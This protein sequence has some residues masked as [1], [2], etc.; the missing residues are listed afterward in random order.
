M[1]IRIF[2]GYKHEDRK[3]AG[4][5]K[6]NLE[7]FGFSVFLAHED[8]EASKDWIEVILQELRSTDV[9]LP[10][11]TSRYRESEYTDQESGVALGRDLPIIPL[12]VDIDPYGLLFT[13]QAEDVDPKNIREC[14]IKI[15]DVISGY[16]HL[17][18]KLR[19]SLIEGFG[20]SRDFEDS[21]LKSEY[22]LRQAPY[23]DLEI[24]WILRM[25]GQNYNIYGCF[26]ACKNIEQLIEIHE[27]IVNPKLVKHFHHMVE[28][29]EEYLD[30]L[31]S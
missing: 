7:L 12:K 10:L 1:S 29:W 20:D 11:L 3:L 2:I 17:Q 4:E 19:K 5:F 24:N 22:L 25:A 8:I 23:T 14:C 30:K 9:F 31:H 16:S 28:A 15:L 21:T 26:E 6:R 27:R 13:K 18:E